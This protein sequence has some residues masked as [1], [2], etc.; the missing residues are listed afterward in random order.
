MEKILKLQREIKTLKNQID[1]YKN[2]A[3]GEKRDLTKVEAT[4]VNSILDQIDEKLA[5]IKAE[6]RINKLEED[7][8]VPEQ[9]IVPE[10]HTIEVGEKN[11]RKQS[12]GEF[13][14]MVARYDMP[15]GTTL[16]GKSCGQNAVLNELREMKEA[17]G[18]QRA[19]T[20]AN[21][22]IPS[23]GG[24]LVGEDFNK[25]LLKNTW[26]TSVLLP[27]CTPLP[28]STES[29]SI[30]ING[31]DETSRADGS[32]YGGVRAYW[33][34]EGGEITASKP[35]FKKINFNLNKLAA[36][37][38][39]TDEL[40]MDSTALEASINEFF[41]KEMSFK[42]DTAIINGDGVGKPLGIIQSPALISITKETNQ[43]A[44][45]IVY[46]NIIK[47]YARINSQSKVAA[48]W[49]A[50][51]DIMP[52]LMTMSIAV[53]TG[54][55]PVF[56]PANG[57]TGKPYDT[58]F[59]KPIVFTEQSPTL[60]AVGDI[61]LADMSQYYVATK[62]GIK[63]A[64]SLHVRFVY[65]EWAFRWTYRIDGKPIWNSALTPYSAGDTISPFV[66]IAVRE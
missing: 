20:G 26:E 16:N 56:M 30:S 37:F 38:Y 10:T 41:P 4:E 36:L 49:I 13:L 55:V 52:Q 1:E 63:S 33:V 32:R 48:I 65:D 11:E 12:F 58:L 44:T 5:L 54:G 6:T 23:E 3:E 45:T 9:T 34:A 40:L 2:K 19:A 21:E 29:N 60:G 24:F 66:A 18:E 62:G 57:A 22:L 35:K 27:K 17:R 31:V 61:V 14:Q 59:G 53:G 50:N 43:V 51:A 39:S 47:M 15:Q 28:I 46:E 7:L 25:T 42:I 64:S 8:T